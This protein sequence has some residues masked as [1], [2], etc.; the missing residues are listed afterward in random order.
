MAAAKKS[1]DSTRPVASV[2]ARVWS[3]VG[4][5]GTRVAEERD[6]RQRWAAR[7]AV[8]AETWSFRYSYAGFC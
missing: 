7:Y 4:A 5:R 8:V 2:W 3:S 6:S 1:L